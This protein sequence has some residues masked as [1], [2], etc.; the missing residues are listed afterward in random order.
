M[1]QLF[2][3]IPTIVG[4]LEPH[5]KLDEAVVF[6]AE[7][8]IEYRQ[9]FNT[10]VF[11][12]MVCYRRTGHNESDEPRFTQPGMWKIIEKH[13]DPRTLYNK[14]LIARGD[15]DEQ[16]AKGMEAKF[17]ADLQARL[18]NAREKPLPYTYQEPELL[19]KALKKTNADADFQESPATGISRTEIDKILGHLLSFP[20]GFTPISQIAKLTEAKK[21]LVSTGKIDW[22]LGELLAYSSL[23]LDGHDVPSQGLER[24]LLAT[25]ASSPAL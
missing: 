14:K 11:I 15:V 13:E 10:D 8:A 3:A 4:S 6:A 9:M 2:G 18:D 24:T 22:Q 1:E 12:D 23:L 16:L 5:D 20:N 19:W 25:N 21:Q 7:L 17:R